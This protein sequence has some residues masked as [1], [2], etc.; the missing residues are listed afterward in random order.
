MRT[1]ILIFLAMAAWPLA[2]RQRT[3]AIGVTDAVVSWRDVSAPVTTTAALASDEATQTVVALRFPAWIERVYVNTTYARVERG[4]PLLEVYS[5]QV[6]AAEQDYLFAV[7]NEEQLT[8]SSVPGVADGVRTLLADARSRLEQEQV[9]AGEIARL[10]RTHTAESH[11]TIAAPSSGLV[12]ERA[13]LPGLR[14][15]PGMVLY[16]LAALAPIWAF[17]QV[18]ESDLGRIAAGQPAMLTLDAF[19]GRNFPARVDFINPQVDAASRTAKVRLVIEN[20]DRRLFPGMYGTATIQVAMGRQLIL[21]ASA[22]LQTGAQSLAFVDLGGGNLRPQPVDLGPRIGSD[23]VVRGGLA[24]GT[25]VV[26]DANF[27]VASE[28]QLSAAAG[29]YAPPPPGVGANAAAPSPGPTAKIELT[30][31]PSPPR[32]GS[33]SFRVR[34][35]SAAGAPI[36]GAQVSVR[37]FMPAMPA[38]GMAQMD[39]RVALAERGGGLYEGKGELGSGGRWQVTIQATRQGQA[40]AR[41]QA[42]LAATGGM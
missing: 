34:L 42:T 38:M 39:V 37:L 8:H 40:V 41:L 33:N 13:A 28:A 3:Q 26:A 17:A 20:R 22:V 23:Y 27:L 36:T 24:P 19:P 25:R 6:L 12:T 31:A 32:K 15:E 21:P 29:S 30:T 18:N 2:A 14:A 9:P 11:L 5:P 7:K 10:E 35:S 1:K 16:K 4:Q